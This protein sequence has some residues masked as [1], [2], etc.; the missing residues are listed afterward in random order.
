MVVV[1]S[2]DLPDPVGEQPTDRATTDRATTDGQWWKSLADE[3]VPVALKTDQ[4]HSARM[5]DYYLGGKDNFPADREAA[6]QALS[7]FPNA[8]IA[9][10]QNREFMIRATR[11][12]AGEVGIR[13]FLDIGTGIPTSPNLHEAAQSIAPDARVVY[14]DNDPI[15]LTHARAL[16]TG[17]PAGR[18]AYIDA[19]LHD[20]ERILDAP[21]LRETLDLSRPVAL[22]LISIFPFIPDTDDPHGILRRLLDALAPGSHL[23][24]TH[25][26]A[27]FDPPAASRL[28]DTYHRQGIP[29]QL[30]SR[31]EVE[32]LFAGLDLIDPGVQIVHRWRP[33]GSAA[34]LTDV[35]VAGYGGV[36]VKR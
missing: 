7:V 30:R 2:A 35:Q 27:D 22:S 21:E 17:T 9:A 26:S 13:Q 28:M 10:R 14:A 8:R 5:Y 15:V 18:T 4:P 3:H 29:L 20:T 19:D 33:D 12:L 36:A 16:L 25:L 34:D 32:G 6:E 1:S 11:Y 23:V 31:A 24:L